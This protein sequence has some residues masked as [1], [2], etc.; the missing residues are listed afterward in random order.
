MALSTFIG[1]DDERAQLVEQVAGHRLVTVVGPGGIGK[2]RLVREVLADLAPAFDEVVVG[3]LSEIEAADGLDAAVA[4]RLGHTSLDG[5]LAAVAGRRTLVVLDT[6]E[7]LLPALAGLV[8]ALVLG[9]PGTTVLATS[10][11]PLGVDGERVVPLG[12][13]A[14]PAPDDAAEV[15]MAS[16]AVAL[17]LDR[18]R[19]AGASWPSPAEHLQ[20]VVALCRRLDGIPLALELAASRARALTPAD[21]LDHLD[22]RFDLLRR[23]GSDRG[24]G[25]HASLRAAVDASYDALSPDDQ[26][27][28]RHLAVFAGPFPADLAHEVCGDEGS[29]ALSTIDRLSRLVDRSVVTARVVDGRTRY[30]LLDTLRDYAAEQLAAAGEWDAVHERFVTCMVAQAD[31]FVAAALERWTPGL[32]DSVLALYRSLVGAIA[33][34]VEHDEGPERSFRLVLPL[35]GALSQSLAGEAAGV[36]LRVLE[37]WPEG[38]EPLRPEAT[39]VVANAALTA[40]RL[41]AAVALAAQSASSPAASTIARLVAERVL[42]FAARNAGHTAAAR[43]LF[44]T[45]RERAAQLGAGAFE[46]ELA[47]FA[48]WAAPPGEEEAALAEVAEV[49]R[50]AAARDERINVVRADVIAAYLAMVAG[51]HDDARTLVEQA[52]A[53]AEALDYPWGRGAS[54]RLAAVLA[55]AAGDAGAARASWQRSVEVFVPHG[56]LDEATLVLR[57]AAGRALASG[58]EATAAALLAAAPRGAVAV[59]ADLGWRDELAGVGAGEGPAMDLPEALRAAAGV[60]AGAG[61]VA[62]WPAAAVGPAAAAAAAPGSAAVAV[63]P[64]V[65]SLRRTGDGWLAAWAGREVLLRHR[66]GIEDLAVLL[67]RPGREVHCLELAGGADVGGD[68]GPALDAT[69]RRAYEARIRDL[70]VEVDEARDAGDVGRV[71]RAEAELDAL[72]QQLAEAFGLGGRARRGGSAAERA[73]SAVTARIRAACQRIAEVHPELGRHLEASVRTGTWC[74]YRPETDVSWEVVDR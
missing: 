66:K 52:R 67:R 65:G 26:R 70:Q 57:A 41:E 69:A 1:R 55:A 54:L 61:A 28:F 20:A 64:R 34:C 13:L 4:G 11:Q 38:D 7:H 12:P 37:R 16:A 5:L 74:C 71:E 33:W 9:D 32:V 29:D 8:E 72:V 43:T 50:A 18:A 25:R 30:L 44:T 23:A 6:C 36:G 15:A 62:P 48:A 46:R 59:G 17:F 49:R 19:A 10:R 58:D 63:V 73:R 22:R 27:F 14:L 47:L 60:L 3:E 68:A 39:A 56:D 45:A 51:R 42:A 31:R 2:T 53:G 21:L 24:D 40:G 35:W